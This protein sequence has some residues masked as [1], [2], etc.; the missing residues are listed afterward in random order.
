[1]LLP[2]HDLNA[3][4]RICLMF[5]VNTVH[6]TKVDK[7]LSTVCYILHKTLSHKS[8]TLCLESTV[9]GQSEVQFL[10]KLGSLPRQQ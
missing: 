3:R 9:A 7:S 10:Q 2:G 5:N 1:M 8:R 4:V 6:Y